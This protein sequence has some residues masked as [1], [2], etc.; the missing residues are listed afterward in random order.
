MK[1]KQQ[2]QSEI[3]NYFEGVEVGIFA[4]IGRI[5]PKVTVA[6]DNGYTVI[7]DVETK[8]TQFI[9]PE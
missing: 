7:A 1:L 3:N 6:L 8:D 4:Y 9:V 2:L 5:G